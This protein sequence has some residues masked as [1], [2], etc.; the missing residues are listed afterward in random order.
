LKPAS[1]SFARRS[2]SLVS[3]SGSTEWMRNG[4]MIVRKAM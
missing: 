1:A 3:R 2:S 4:S